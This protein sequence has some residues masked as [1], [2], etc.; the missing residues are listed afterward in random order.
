MPR[1]GKKRHK[2]RQ[3]MEAQNTLMVAQNNLM[4]APITTDTRMFLY[5]FAP[6]SG[7]FPKL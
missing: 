1:H 4:V 7:V 2:N 5:F 3:M 6:P